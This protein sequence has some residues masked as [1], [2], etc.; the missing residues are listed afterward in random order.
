MDDFTNIA[1]ILILFA[2]AFVVTIL[3]TPLLTHFLYKYKL[4]KQIRT[5]GAPIYRKMHQKKE[6]TPTMGGL[7]IWLTTLVLAVLFWLLAQGTASPLL[8]KLNF[9]TRAETLLPLGALGISALIGLFDD[10]LGIKRIGPKGGGFRMRH[11]IFLYLAVA[12][13]GAWWF[14]YKLD[15]DLI[16]VPGLG[17]FYIGWWYLPIFAFIIF[18]TAFSTNETDGLDGLAGGVLLIAYAAYG[19][20]AY[21]QGKTD[22]A[23]FCAV[24]AGCL[25]AFLWFNIY[26]ARFFMGDTGSMSL[27]VT[28]G[29]VAMLT[30][31]ILVLPLIAFIL[32][33]ESASV[34]IQITSRKIFGRK[35]F[36]STPIHH[37][38]EARGWPESKVTMRFW[39]IAGVIASLG[40]II[41][42]IG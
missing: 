9:L 8:D 41:G 16:H 7:L 4:G 34:I 37:H 29:V 38:F 6:K 10:I 27:G 22:L 18:A 32:V 36:L 21:T 40:L 15:W 31:S 3:W 26:P 1:R 20:I 11:R 23:V 17:D 25:L 5:E 42:L 13:G 30:N 2:I 28:L 14:F 39:I 33:L 35:V 19:V 24:I 12:L